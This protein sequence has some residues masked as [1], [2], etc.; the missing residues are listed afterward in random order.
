MKKKVIFSGALCALV[1][2]LTACVPKEEALEAESVARLSDPAA[3]AEVPNQIQEAGEARYEPYIPERLE[4]LKG[5][6]SFALFFHAEWCPLCRNL[7]AQ[8]IEN[9]EKLG[10]AVILK[11]D[12]DTVLELRREYGVSAQTTVVFFDARGEVQEK[13]LNPSFEEI[14]D[15]FT[16]QPNL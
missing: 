11:A 16:G 7:E 9:L 5:K 13:K 15:F 8:L 2:L 12:Y 14:Q 6:R 3:E 1:F 10:R 4:E